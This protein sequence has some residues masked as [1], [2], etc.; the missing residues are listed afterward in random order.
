[1]RFKSIHTNFRSLEQ[2]LQACWTKLDRFVKLKK[3]LPFDERVWR[4]ASLG[5]EQ[6]FGFFD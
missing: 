5:R 2:S 3:I 4:A 6:V 1:M